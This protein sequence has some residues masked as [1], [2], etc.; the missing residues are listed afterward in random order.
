MNQEAA[1]IQKN[2]KK[3]QILV[4]ITKVYDYTENIDLRG[5]G[6]TAL[7]EGLSVGG[8]LDLR[9]TGITA[10]PEGLSVGGDLDLRGTGI[11]A[12]PEGLFGRPAK[13]SWRR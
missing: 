5:I 12:L 9:D 2:E 11:T 7:P 1:V 10:L 6:I 4:V 8:Y 13:K 3:Q